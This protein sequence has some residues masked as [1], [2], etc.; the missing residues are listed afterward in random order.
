[1]NRA[2]EHHL[3]HNVLAWLRSHA[4]P[5][6]TLTALLRDLDPDQR[7]D[8]VIRDYAIQHLLDSAQVP[9]RSTARLAIRRLNRVHGGPS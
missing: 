4:E 8:D 9:I 3:V 2:Y 1:M 5:D 6:G 7:Q